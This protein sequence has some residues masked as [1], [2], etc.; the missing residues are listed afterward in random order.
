MMLPKLILTDI[1]GVWT[2]GGMYYDNTGNEFKKFNT[3]DSAGV[4]FC[5]L[6]SIPVGIITGEKNNIVQN[7]A[8]KLGIEILF[9]GIKNK[10][11]LVEDLCVK[12][13]ISISEVAYIGDD[14]NDI[15]VLKKV[16]ISGCPAD[17]PKYVK[18][19]CNMILDKEGGAGVFREFV[20][21]ILGEEQLEK[22]LNFY[23]R[24][25]EEFK[26]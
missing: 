7:R 6:L 18:K 23:F 3:S 13:N 4:L 12:Y 8:N 24:S 21:K 1:D 5:K 26:Q 15:L 25:L 10:L 9:M 22:A 16:G 2:D 19:H 20:E 14:I 11:Q 17:A